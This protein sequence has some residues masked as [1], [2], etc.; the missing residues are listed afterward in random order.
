MITP[1]MGVN[2]WQASVGRGALLAL[3]VFFLLAM[4]WTDLRRWIIPN[5]L[6]LPGAVLV[7]ALR[8]L[9]LP[10]TLPGALLGGALGWTLFWL[11]AHLG[12]GQLGGGDVRLA[13]F[14]GLLTGAV[15]VIP[16]LLLGMAAGGVIAFGLIASGRAQMDQGFPYGPA[17]SLGAMTILLL[18]G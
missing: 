12:D 14:I 8:G 18:A 5:S 10:G 11:L 9:L 3:G 6:L 1:L 4:S 13:G 15:W 2:G 17:L 7:L 16:A